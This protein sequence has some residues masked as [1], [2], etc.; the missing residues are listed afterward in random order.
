MRE[1][2]AKIQPG[3]RG[4]LTATVTNTGVEVSVAH[5]LERFGKPTVSGWSGR[6]WGGKG[7]SAGARSAWSW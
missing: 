7:W 5:R 6:E 2:L 4:Q 3:K 1:A